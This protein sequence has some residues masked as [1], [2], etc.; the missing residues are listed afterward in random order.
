MNSKFIPE[1][2]KLIEVDDR[3]AIITYASEKE[4]S[5][6]YFRT[7]WRNIPGLVGQ[8]WEVFSDRVGHDTFVRTS[9]GRW[10]HKGRPLKSYPVYNYDYEVPRLSDGIREAGLIFIKFGELIY[11]HSDWERRY[12]DGL[13]LYR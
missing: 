11:D 9:M 2:G 12:R 3:P 8:I 6:E 7:E 1:V 4:F 5:V 13:R 10:R